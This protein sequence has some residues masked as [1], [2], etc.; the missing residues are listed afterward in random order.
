M[1][2]IASVTLEITNLCN[3]NCLHC[4]NDSHSKKT[5][6]EMD[7]NTTRLLL[8]DLQ[9][10][11]QKNIDDFWITGGEPTLHSNFNNIIELLYSFGHKVILVSNGM[12][13][14]KKIAQLREVKHAIKRIHLSLEGLQDANDSI[15]GKGVFEHLTTN[16]IPLLKSE[17]FHVCVTVHLTKQNQFEI[18]ELAALIIDKLDCDLKLGVL[19]PIGRAQLNLQHQIL[20]SAELFDCIKTVYE[21]KANYATKRIWHDWD[22]FSEDIKFYVQDYHGQTSCPAGLQKIIAYTS[23]YDVYPCV[24]L[25]FPFFNFGN[26]KEEGDLENILNKPHSQEIYRLLE[27]KHENCYQCK[28]FKISCQ[29]GCPAIA[30]GFNEQGKSISAMDP[31][32]FA[33]LA[34]NQGNLSINC[35]SNSC[36]CL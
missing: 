11:N 30:Y 29:G 7:I 26:F 24:Q 33:H 15:R 16:V 19:R 34:N 35:L 17:D 2:N 1:L 22:I 31:Y 25:R 18:R 4:F 27:T 10:H 21:L 13:I 8:L 28:F 5:V 9:K 20:S 36:K 14:D 32:C 23:N 12:F 6:V 3:L